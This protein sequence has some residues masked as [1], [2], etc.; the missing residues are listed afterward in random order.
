MSRRAAAST[1]STIVAVIR[2][3]QR[4]QAGLE[5]PVAGPLLLLLI[6]LMLT[7]VFL[8]TIEHGVEGL[9]FTCVMLV[10]AVLRLVVVLGRVSRPRPVRVAVAGRAPPRRT[11]P[12]LRASRL[13]AAEFVVPLR[14]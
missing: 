10:A 4:L 6:A 8:H 3:R 2:L 5:H 13:P 11:V 14:R 7:F 12:L 9:L 1:S